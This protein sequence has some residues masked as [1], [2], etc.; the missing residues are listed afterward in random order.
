MNANHL[1]NF[2]LYLFLLTT[3]I[4]I[5]GWIIFKNWLPEKYFTGF[6]FVPFVFFI[7]TLSFHYYLIRSSSKE[8]IKFTPRFIGASGI[9]MFI[10]CILII[11]YLLIDRHQVVSF[12]I[13]FL[14]CYF[15]YTTFE[16]IS[17]LRYLKSKK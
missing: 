2:V 6:L 10:Y 13:C 15:L 9:K 14:I 16:I 7:I 8:I 11:V 5:A 4:S 12:L 1:K 3:L 17:V